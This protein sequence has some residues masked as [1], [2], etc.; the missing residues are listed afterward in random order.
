MDDRPKK[1]PITRLVDC[2]RE[3]PMTNPPPPHQPHLQSS[4]HVVVE[5]VASSSGRSE[6]LK[7]FYSGSL[8][9]MSCSCYLIS[10][11]IILT[12]EWQACRHLLL[13]SRGSGSTHLILLEDMIDS[14]PFHITSNKS[15]SIWLF[16]II[17]TP[18]E[19]MNYLQT[20]MWLSI[21]AVG[22]KH[23][24]QIWIYFRDINMHGRSWGG[25]RVYSP[26]GVGVNY[27]V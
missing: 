25:G 18:V 19:C 22:P 6:L 5:I 12:G 26:R 1:G 11:P 20:L 14:C 24:R 2:L 8:C 9:A 4:I 13:T 3:I 10:V 17:V 27:R 15:L 23:E 21:S 7:W 16:T